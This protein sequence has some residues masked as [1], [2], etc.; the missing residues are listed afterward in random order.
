MLQ[1]D[2][3]SV[4]F[5]SDRSL[6]PTNL[7]RPPGPPTTV[8]HPKLSLPRSTPRSFYTQPSSLARSIQHS[9]P[10][11]DDSLRL[12]SSGASRA[13]ASAPFPSVC[14]SKVLI[15]HRLTCSWRRLVCGRRGLC[16]MVRWRRWWVYFHHILT[17]RISVMCVLH[18]TRRWII[19]GWLADHPT[20]IGEQ[21]QAFADP[22]LS[23][24]VAADKE[25]KERDE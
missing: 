14:L 20:M 8:L 23:V 16:I 25:S 6:N 24:E 13:R 9:T 5:I 18:I 7:Q 22:S 21:R 17:V 3:W 1:G 10:N 11:N 15:C 19:V 12:R 2:I 4:S